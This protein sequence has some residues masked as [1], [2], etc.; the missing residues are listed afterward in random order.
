MKF[1]VL[2]KKLDAEFVGLDCV[3][4]FSDGLSSDPGDD[5]SVEDG[6]VEDGPVEDGSAG[7]G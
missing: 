4:K 7:D 3:D 1:R 5:G 6:S 2:V